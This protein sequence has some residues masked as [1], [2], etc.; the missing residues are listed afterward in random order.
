MAG[1]FRVSAGEGLAFY[2]QWWKVYFI[3]FSSGLCIYKRDC[4]GY[5]VVIVYAYLE[6]L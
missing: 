5:F 6:E 4:E 1:I 2:I 3:N